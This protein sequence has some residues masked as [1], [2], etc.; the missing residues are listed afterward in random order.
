MTLKKKKKK[1]LKDYGA[2]LRI[3]VRYVFY[4]FIKINYLLPKYTLNNK[5]LK[6]NIS[7]KIKNFRFT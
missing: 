6:K 1:T 7:L 4:I 3:L 5:T 2:K